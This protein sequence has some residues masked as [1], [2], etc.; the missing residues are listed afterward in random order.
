MRMGDFSEQ[1]ELPDIIELSKSILEYMSQYRDA[2]RSDDIISAFRLQ[3]SHGLLIFNNLEKAYLIKSSG[4]EG[5]YVPTF[6]AHAALQELQ[7]AIIAAH[8]P[9]QNK[10]MQEPPRIFYR[11]LSIKRRNPDFSD[12]NHAMDTVDNLEH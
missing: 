12:W 4:K 9:E 7:W 5:Y 1:F 11:Q 8:E 2:L 3:R 10:N 6:K